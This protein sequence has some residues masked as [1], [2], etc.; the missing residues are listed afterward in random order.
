VKIHPIEKRV[1]FTLFR[2][3]DGL[4]A[5]TV[6]K[7]LEVTPSAFYVAVENLRNAELIRIE[8]VRLSLTP[9]A[10][11]LVA[12]QTV[13]SSEPGG[14]FKNIPEKFKGPRIAR[15]EFYVPKAHQFD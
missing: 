14:R 5:F 10:E 6:Y 15:D 7:K 12:S 3:T 4:L 11:A 13:K 1:L 2:A 9:K 8:D